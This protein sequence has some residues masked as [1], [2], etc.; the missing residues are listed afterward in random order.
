VHGVVDWDWDIPAVTLPP[1]IFL[2]VLAA[3]PGLRRAPEPF[4]DP[5]PAGTGVRAVALVGIALLLCGALA[6]AALPAI[7]QSRT[8]AAE[9]ASN[10]DTAARDADVAARLNPVAVR[11]LLVASSIEIRRGR[12]VEARRRLLEAAGRQPENPEVWYRI[13]QLSQQLADRG[14]YQT[15][16]ARF[17]Q[18]DPVNPVTGALLRQ[19]LAIQ[20]PA[21]ASATATGT[22]LPGAPV[23][24]PAPPAAP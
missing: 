24:A 19:A 6:S 2:G 17:A 8:E 1:L 16:I 23:T 11:P 14:S 10:P 3:R 13:A 22:P 4:A 15:A 7:S 21:N 5:E 12:L 18:L 20:A 9:T